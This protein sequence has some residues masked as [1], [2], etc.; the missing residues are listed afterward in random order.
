MTDGGKSTQP[1]GSLGDRCTR[2]RLH[3]RDRAHTGSPRTFA[4]KSRSMVTITSGFHSSTCST[5]TVG[6]PAL[7]LGRDVARAEEFDGLDVDRA[8]EPGFEP[9][10]TARVIDAR[11]AVRRNR[12]D[13]LADRASWFRAA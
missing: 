10:R 9:A 13:P 11:A 7:A 5:E 3:R 8:A 4:A 2:P 6:E 1:N 12:V